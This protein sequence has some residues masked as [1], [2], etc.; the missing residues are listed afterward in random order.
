MEFMVFDGYFSEFITGDFASFLIQFA[1][2]PR[3]Y[4]QTLPGSGRTNEVHN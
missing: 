1:I 4:F 2:Q 3:M